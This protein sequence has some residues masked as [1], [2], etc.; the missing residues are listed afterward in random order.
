MD[1]LA[2]AY[3]WVKSFHLMAVMAWMAGLFYLPRLFVNLALVPPDSAAERERLLL[4]A[5]KLQRFAGLLALPAIGLGLVLWLGYGVGSASATDGGSIDSAVQ[6]TIAESP[7]NRISV[8]GV[9]F[10]VQR[11][12]KIRKPTSANTPTVQSA[13][14][15]VEDSCWSFVQISVPAT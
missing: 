3:L 9:N 15:S 8:S 12:R 6:R 14:A 7:P 4:M 1:F 2:P 11:A 10:S 5:H 13:P